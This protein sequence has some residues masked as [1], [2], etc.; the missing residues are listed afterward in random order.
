MKFEKGQQL[1]LKV[2]SKYIY[3][4]HDLNACIPDRCLNLSPYV[5]KVGILRLISAL[6]VME[7]DLYPHVYRIKA[8]VC[9]L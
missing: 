8:H 5:L 3:I 1:Y 7:D 9:V 4:M 6:M 2:Q